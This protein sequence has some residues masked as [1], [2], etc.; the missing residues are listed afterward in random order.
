MSHGH[1]LE[2]GLNHV[3]QPWDSHPPRH[4]QDW[5]KQGWDPRW[6]V[7]PPPPYP[8]AQEELR[9][10]RSGEQLLIVAATQRAVASRPAM[11]GEA[12]QPQDGGQRAGS[13]CTA[14]MC[15]HEP[16]KVPRRG[17]AKEAAPVPSQRRKSGLS[18][19][20]SSFTQS[21]PRG[22]LRRA[23]LCPGWDALCGSCTVS[24]T[25][26]P[27]LVCPIQLGCDPAGPGSPRAPAGSGGA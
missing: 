24:G 4:L 20:A 26:P 9:L 18:S 19:P 14:R 22:P 7:G 15:V 16:Q 3:G 11:N 17:Q 2:L 10:L 1:L 5:G 27:C 8:A 12:T 25:G 6:R 13:R 21:V 23:G